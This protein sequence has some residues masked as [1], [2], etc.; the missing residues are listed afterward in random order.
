VK[1]EIARLR[2]VLQGAV[3][4]VGFRPFTY[5]LAADL[6]LN[7]WVSNTAQGLIVEVEGPV[8]TLKTFLLRISREKPANSFIQSSQNIFLDPCGYKTFEIK[9]SGLAEEKTTIV[10][11][12]IATCPE[13]LNEVFD[14]KDRRYLYPF[15]NCTHCGPRYSIVNSLP[16]DRA[17][18]SMKA[19][20][21]CDECQHEYEDPS[22]RRFHA[23]PNACPQCGPELSLWNNQGTV[24][25]T[26][27]SVLSACV[28]AVQNGSVV[29]VKGLGGFHLM[30]DANNEGSVQT[31]RQKSTLFI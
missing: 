3:Q 15:T 2:V 6:N 11:P 4:G 31:L 5:R 19:F 7:G 29:A 25:A 30:V 17:N 13:C 12:D 22:N 24:L 21:M 16:Y 28:S 14:Q 18:T 26:K 1:K 10:L 27:Q 20:Q 9:K 8:P 23:Q